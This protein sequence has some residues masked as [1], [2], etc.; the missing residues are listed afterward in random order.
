MSVKTDKLLLQLLLYT[1]G[2]RGAADNYR[3]ITLLTRYWIHLHLIVRVGLFWSSWASDTYFA[4]LDIYERFVTA[5]TL[6]LESGLMLGMNYL[7]VKWYIYH[8][9]EEKSTLIGRHLVRYVLCD[10]ITSSL[11]N[12]SSVTSQNPFIE[13][14]HRKLTVW[15]KCLL[16]QFSLWWFEFR[17]Q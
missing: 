4:A 14:I 15:S 10:L 6:R 9:T 8:R 17:S 2:E 7:V 3:P 12:Q 13:K 11:C 1:S 16:S 5:F